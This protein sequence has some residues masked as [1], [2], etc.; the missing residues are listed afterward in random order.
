MELSE[1]FIQSSGL[2]EDQVNAIKEF[3]SNQIAELKKTYDETYSKTANENAEKILSGA[4]AK[5]FESTKIERQQGEKIADYYERAWKESNQTRLSEI[6]KLKEEYDSK[7]KNFK[8]SED[9]SKSLSVLQQK[10]DELQAKEAEFDKIMSSGIVD[11]HEELKTKYYGMKQ[12]VA[13][14]SVRPSFP[15]T[16]NKFE[17]KA[18]WDSFKK[19]IM[20]EYDIEMVDGEALAISKENKHKQSKL[21]DLVAKDSEIQGLL[22][23][24][25]QSGLNGQVKDLLK[26]EGIPFEVPKGANSVDRAKLIREQLSKEKI[27]PTD[28]LYPV[29]FKE[30]NEKLLK[31]A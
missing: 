9:I 2:N 20:D 16:V 27:A 26:V 30:Y 24:R 6:D 8:G 14:N 28:P 1:E 4:A 11:Q 15:D 10:Y 29:K 22:E 18:K 5:V 17:L 25:K 12:E 21:S 19:G 31:V 3:G 7:V 13:F 23:G